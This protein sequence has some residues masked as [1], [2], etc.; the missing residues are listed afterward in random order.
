MITE[1]FIVAETREEIEDN[2]V[3]RKF[4]DFLDR[5]EEETKK[6]VPCFRKFQF[7]PCGPTEE[8]IPKEF[9]YKQLFNSTTGQFGYFKTELLEEACEN[10][11]EINTFVSRREHKFFP[12]YD[13]MYLDIMLKDSKKAYIH[14]GQKGF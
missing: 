6:I 12:V 2:V 3:T 9:K 14:D 11:Q 7:I 13:E 10:S 8:D 1:G 4:I 5:F